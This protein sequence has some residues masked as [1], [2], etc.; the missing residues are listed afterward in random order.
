VAGTAAAVAGW[1]MVG[2]V[3]VA[4]AE[5]GQAVTTVAHP[6]IYMIT[7]ISNLVAV[8]ASAFLIGV[9]ALVLAARSSL[10]MGLRVFS[11]VGGVS[12]I[13]AA[14]YFPLPLYFLWAIVVGGWALASPAP[15][16]APKARE[17][18]PV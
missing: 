7:E 14:F 6:V 8:C 2:G 17:V 15:V 13:L 5:G 3:A 1:F 10:P 4:A 16:S 12:G 9:A 18:Q 11:Y